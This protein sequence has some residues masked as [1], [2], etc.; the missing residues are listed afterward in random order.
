MTR[1]CFFQLWKRQQQVKWMRRE[2]LHYMQRDF[3]MQA[4]FLR[5]VYS[6]AC[7]S[8]SCTRGTRA[9]LL[10]LVLNLPDCLIRFGGRNFKTTMFPSPKIFSVQLG[11]LI[12][13]PLCAQREKQGNSERLWIPR[14]L[15]KLPGFLSSK[16]SSV[17]MSKCHTW[18]IF[19]LSPKQKNRVKE[20]KGEIDK[21][22]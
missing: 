17:A 6:R 13:S 8:S 7:E 14:Q 2:G 5:H 22:F 1:E 19:F 10:G 12:A 9:D 3:M 16:R 21:Y 15:R 11:C 4:D 20:R 18:D